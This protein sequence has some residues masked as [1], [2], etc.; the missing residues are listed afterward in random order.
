MLLMCRFARLIINHFTLTKNKS[1]LKNGQQINVIYTK[2]RTSDLCPLSF[3]RHLTPEPELQ[4]AFSLHL[5]NLKI[6]TFCITFK[7]IFKK[8]SRV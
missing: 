6:F 1:V 7:T 2:I 3:I 5:R 4:L 8:H